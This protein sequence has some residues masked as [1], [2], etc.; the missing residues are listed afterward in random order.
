[1]KITS[2]NKSPQWIRT[3]LSNFLESRTLE[4]SLGDLEEKFQRRVRNGLSPWK[5]KLFF[6]AEGL[7]FL[8]MGKLKSDAS[9]QTTINMIRHTFLFFGRLVRKDWSYYLVS[10]LGLT[11]SLTSF[12]F[13]MMFIHDELSYDQFHDQ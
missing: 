5:A 6:I 7:G 4:A 8:R 12:M 13:I 1:M 3:L 9:G 2:K 11:L 10:M